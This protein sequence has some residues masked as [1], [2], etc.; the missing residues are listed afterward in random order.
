MDYIPNVFRPLKSI[1][2]NY[3]RLRDFFEGF[4]VKFTF[5]QS[6]LI[7]CLEQLLRLPLHKILHFTNHFFLYFFNSSQFNTSFYNF[8]Y[9]NRPPPPFTS[10]II[11]PQFKPPHLVKVKDMT[12]V[13]HLSCKIGK[14]SQK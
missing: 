12:Y 11:H 14:V 2:I 13:L 7:F 4:I 5:F 8:F 9:H 10:P 1:I 6:Y 3:N